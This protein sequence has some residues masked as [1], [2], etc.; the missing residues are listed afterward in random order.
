MSD[1]SLVALAEPLVCVGQ[2]VLGSALQSGA[3]EKQACP[4]EEKKKKREENLTAVRAAQELQG[5]RLRF[6]SVEPKYPSAASFVAPVAFGHQ[7]PCPQP[8]VRGGFGV[9]KHVDVVFFL[10]AFPE[11]SEYR[12]PAASCFAEA[13]AGLCW[14]QSNA[15]GCLGWAEVDTAGRNQELFV[16]M[17][18]RRRYKAF[19]CSLPQV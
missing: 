3:R 1:L 13:D 6:T 9:W 16:V 8:A 2:E 15:S 11:V 18:F 10:R 5:A 12:I 17:C 7:F 4:L 19:S 14:S